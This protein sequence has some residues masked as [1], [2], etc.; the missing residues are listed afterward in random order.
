M[1]ISHK[2]HHFVPR[3]YLKQWTSNT[4]GNIGLY[5]LNLR[6]N[7][8]R[9]QC[10]SKIAKKKNLY[11]IPLKYGIDNKLTETF[12]FKMHE[13]LWPTVISGLNSR[14]ALSI[15]QVK[16][17]R[18][19]V[20]IQSLR[21]PKFAKGTKEVMEASSNQ[22]LKDIPFSTDWVYNGIR[23]FPILAKNCCVELYRSLELKNFITSDNP[24]T[25]WI[26]QGSNFTFLKS[27]ALNKDLMKNPYYKIICPVT[28]RYFAILTPNIGIEILDSIKSKVSIKRADLNKV[29]IFNGLTE[30][31]ADKLLFSYILN[32]FI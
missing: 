15:S 5:T 32:D 14:K 18:N 25:H 27:T 28:P 8:P 23:L 22:S 2:E 13:D 12:I 24:A 21:T 19:F 17:L 10:T 16:S 11:T 9:K 1:T 20:I 3:V 4:K 29:N 26:I 30:M 6:D 31:G 7:F